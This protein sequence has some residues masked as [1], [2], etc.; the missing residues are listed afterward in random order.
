MFLGNHEN[1]WL[2]VRM[3]LA[4]DSSRLGSDRMV[5]E[6]GSIRVFPVVN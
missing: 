3:P 1:Y 2:A 5:I 6:D 4:A